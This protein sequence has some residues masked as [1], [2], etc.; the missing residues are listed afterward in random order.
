MA[1][2]EEILY[3]WNTACIKPHFLSMSLWSHQWLSNQV[4]RTPVHIPGSFT[5]K[6][7]YELV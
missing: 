2:I 4:Y 1:H 7:H 3:S 6:Y 5:G